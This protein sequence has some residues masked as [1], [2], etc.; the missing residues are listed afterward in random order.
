MQ[1]FARFWSDVGR[2]RGVHRASV[3]GVV[4]RASLVLF[5]EVLFALR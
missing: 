3:I 4:S 2:L 1:A 5:I